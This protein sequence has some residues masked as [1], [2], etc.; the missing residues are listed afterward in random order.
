MEKQ[1]EISYGMPDIQT[2]IR[3]TQYFQNQK[4]AR[5]NTARE[6]VPMEDTARGM[7]LRGMFLERM[8]LRRILLMRILPHYQ[9]HR[10]NKTN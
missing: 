6:D 1:D 5:E 4:A 9:K 3:V 10:V 2:F 8:L 7:L